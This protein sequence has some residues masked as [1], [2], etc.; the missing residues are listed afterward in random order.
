MLKKPA[1]IHLDT[2]KYQGKIREHPSR[3]R[4]YAHR[5]E[6]QDSATAYL[7]LTQPNYTSLRQHTKVTI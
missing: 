2:S 4:I 7:C 1:A 6:I 3:V 5:A